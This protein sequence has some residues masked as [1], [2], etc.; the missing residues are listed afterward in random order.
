MGGGN[1]DEA[2][3][4][5]FTSSQT[6][7]ET[8]VIQA[9]SP[10][11]ASPM[12][13]S[14]GI[15][16]LYCNHHGSE[17][18]T[19]KNW[20][21]LA[22]PAVAVISTGAGQTSGWDLPRID[23]VEHVLFAQATSCITVPAADVLQTEEGNPAGSLTSVAGYCVGDIKITTDGVSTFAVSGNGQVTQGPNEVAAA[24]LPK[25]YNL[26]DSSGPPDTSPPVISAETATN[27]AAASATITWTTDELSNSVVEF[28][29]TTSYGSTV[30]NAN[31][32]TS[33]SV[34]L[35]NLSANTLYHYRVSSTDA[36]GNT[37][38][39]ADH[40]FQTGGSFTYAPSS[41]S[42]LQG[43]LNSGSASNLASNDASYYA[44]NSTTSGTR[45]S[46]WY[47]SVTVSQAPGSISTLAVTY[48]G[49][50]SRN[51]ITQTLHLYNWTSSSWTQIDSRSV[52][53]SDVTI[54]NTQSTPANFIS[55][56]GEIR[57][58]I[59]GTGNNKNFT[60]LGDFM[61]FT[62]STSGSNLSKQSAGDEQEFT[63][64]SYR[65]NQNYP[66]PF[67]PTTTIQ[68]L[69]AERS[70]VTL[71]VYDMLGREIAILVDEVQDAGYKSV[72]FDASN[73]PSGVYV[74]RLTAG[75]FV[76]MK[77]TLLLK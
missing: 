16:V 18:S 68:F 47:G 40:S 34:P 50:Y 13:S 37:A 77:K 76:D 15:D 44:V 55:A 63:P 25:T 52:G 43:S 20:M 31:N 74:Y 10:G 12:I 26:D 21:N 62:A 45:K 72:R 53:T 2:C 39:S 30:S 8:Y 66:N 42:I 1:I 70:H 29:P 19:N 23:V 49:K 27:I 17:S 36:A 64:A 58:R 9:I 67:N 59:L 69:I 6:D 60:C 24:G 38:T 4:G 61:Q 75:R 46:D 65:L 57:L 54:T 56:T 71:S 33:H 7:V 5:R 73:L 51:G 3:T 48:D 11:G 28:G 22:Q 32:V 14:Q 35:S 41:A